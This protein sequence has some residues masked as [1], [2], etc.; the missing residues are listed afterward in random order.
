[1]QDPGEQ[2]PPLNIFC[3]CSCGSFA[4]Q[5]DFFFLVVFSGLW[6]DG[7]LHAAR[8]GLQKGSR[9]RRHVGK[10]CQNR[11]LLLPLWLH[12]DRDQGNGCSVFREFWP[13]TDE[14]NWAYV[15]CNKSCPP[16]HILPNIRVCNQDFLFTRDIFYVTHCDQIIFSSF[17]FRILSLWLVLCHKVL[18]PSCHENVKERVLLLWQV[19]LSSGKRAY[20]K[21]TLDFWCPNS[22]Y[23]RHRAQCW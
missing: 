7:V 6:R 11:R 17:S 3:P 21:D 15:S 5:V 20:Y 10:R 13:T 9:G 12:G 1:M 14:I 16:T 23:F 8:H 19:K 2:C 18:E 4:S 22:L